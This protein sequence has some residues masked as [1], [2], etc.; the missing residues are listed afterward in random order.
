MKTS[1]FTLYNLILALWV[2]GIAAFT[3]IVTPVIFRS[4]GRD[5]AGKI[6]GELFPGYFLYNLV[7]AALA[8]L[9]FFVVAGEPSKTPYRLSLFLLT[10]ALIINVFIV[11]KLHPDTVQ[12]KQAVTS[13]ERESP[14]SPMRKRFAKLHAVSAVLNLLL[15]ADG[16]ALLAVAPLLKR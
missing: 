2:G 4:F 12:V 8:L 1:W 11:F 6:V 13:F 10:A 5:L 3:F 14:D 9:L 7:L 16:A 15:L